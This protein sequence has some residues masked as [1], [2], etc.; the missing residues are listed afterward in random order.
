MKLEEIISDICSIKNKS[1]LLKYFNKMN[2]ISTLLICNIILQH[3]DL[4]SIDDIGRTSYEKLIKFSV[5][6]N[7]DLL[8]TYG[9]INSELDVETYND[10]LYLNNQTSETIILLAT[11][12]K[13]IALKH[14]DL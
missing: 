1:L 11:Y 14:N 13:S 2:N 3:N 10:Y 9:F 5:N 12:I 7:D 8:I 6:S 4:I